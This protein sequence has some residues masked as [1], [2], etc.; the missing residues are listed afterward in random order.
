MSWIAVSRISL[1]AL[2]EAIEHQAEK[3][4][5][6]IFVAI[7]AFFVLTVFAFIAMILL[8]IFV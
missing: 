8:T 4:T 5:L 7:A 3:T 2:R 6:S 1:P